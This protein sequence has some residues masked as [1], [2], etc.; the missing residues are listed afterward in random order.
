MLTNHER[1]QLLREYR[2]EPASAAGLLLACAAGLLIVWALA[3]AGIEI[4]TFS[5]GGA[6]A[7]TASGAR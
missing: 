2:R 6:P 4:L 5:T 3:V 1:K 7:Q